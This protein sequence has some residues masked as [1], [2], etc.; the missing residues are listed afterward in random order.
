MP[1]LKMNIALSS[2]R[3]FL[4]VGGFYLVFDGTIGFLMEQSA[5]GLVVTFFV[6][7]CSVKYNVASKWVSD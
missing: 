3:I 7:D 4:N 2:P 1:F 6:V 5:Q